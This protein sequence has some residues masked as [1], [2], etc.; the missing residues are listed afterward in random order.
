MK[1]KRLFS[2]MLALVLCVGVLAGTVGAATV[3]SKP[4]VID[5][6]SITISKETATVGDT[7]T[8]TVKV[9]D[10]VAVDRVSI[11]FWNNDTS[12]QLHLWM[13]GAEGSDIFSCEFVV[14]KK[15]LLVYGGYFPS[16]LMI[17]RRTRIAY[18]FQPMNVH[19]RLLAL[20]T[21]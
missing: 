13:T 16:W 12:E 3:D 14:T 8:V 6:D 19:F 11:D 5:K 17:R 7:I 1:E 15:H 21:L 18:I 10:N 4:P 9:T 20:P 2:L